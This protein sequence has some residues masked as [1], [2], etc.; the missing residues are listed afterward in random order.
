M[1]RTSESPIQDVKMAQIPA[2]KI[3]TL[4]T[5]DSTTTKT[6]A[7][8]SASANLPTITAP[9]IIEDFTL[10]PKLPLELRTE[11]WISALPDSLEILV[12]EQDLRSRLH[13]D[14]EVTVIPTTLLHANQESRSI[15]LKVYKPYL[16]PWGGK[17]MFF[18]SGR[19]ILRIHR[20]SSTQASIS[21]YRYH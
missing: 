9:E 18:N 20:P 7:A 13:R 17:P 10:F 8:A 6:F 14:N 21:R 15:A 2:T 11:I 12:T 19:D 3:E 5:A 4:I 1:N 16:G